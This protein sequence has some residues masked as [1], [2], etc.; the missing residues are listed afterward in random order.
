M[1]FK[2]QMPVVSSLA[3]KSLL[4]P[5][6]AKGLNVHES[7]EDE[8]S[9]GAKLLDGLTS[10]QSEASGWNALLRDGPYPDGRPQSLMLIVLL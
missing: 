5:F 2:F 6:A 4:H 8:M 7:A 10:R 3:M 1:N 9:L